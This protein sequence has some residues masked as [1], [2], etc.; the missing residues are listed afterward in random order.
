MQTLSQDQIATITALADE[1][2]ANMPAFL[3]Y[4]KLASLETAPI[5]SYHALIESLEK[6]RA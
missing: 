6:K 3:K 5:I 2:G 1:V 4:H